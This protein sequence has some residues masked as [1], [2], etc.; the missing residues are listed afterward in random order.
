MSLLADVEKPIKKSRQIKKRIIMEKLTFSQMESINGGG[1]NW[2]RLVQDT[3]L[4]CGGLL[5]ISVM[6]AT[7]DPAGAFGVICQT[8]FGGGS[9]AAAI[10]E[11]CPRCKD[12]VMGE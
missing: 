4:K 6:F 7:T 8:L 11:Y 5:A 1:W 3:C 9:L 10:L 12:E 2:G